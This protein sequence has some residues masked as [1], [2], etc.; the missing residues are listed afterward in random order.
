MPITGAFENDGKAK[1]SCCDRL[2][3][4]FI[5]K[6]RLKARVHLLLDSKAEIVDYATEG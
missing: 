6:R 5:G 2:E 4:V 3:I 1:K